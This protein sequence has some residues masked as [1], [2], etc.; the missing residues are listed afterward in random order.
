MNPKVFI[1]FTSPPSILK[2]VITWF[3]GG[4]TSHVM[5]SY[6][7]PFWGGEWTA[8]SDWDGV[9]LYQA[10]KTFKYV[11]GKYEC[12]FDVTGGI[13][14]ISALINQPYDYVNLLAIGFVALVWKIFKK[15][16]KNPWKN[17]KAQICSEFAT[18]F[19]KGAK[20]QGGNLPEVSLWDPESISPADVM[21]Y[22]D[23]HPELFDP[24]KV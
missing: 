15:K 7:D 5:L 8:A 14:A 4:K 21:S 12:K 16:I 3:T 1:V 19:L 24:Q 18:R 22:C 2:R 23:R 6:I 20:F 10:N 9:R 17:A 13:Q 11:I